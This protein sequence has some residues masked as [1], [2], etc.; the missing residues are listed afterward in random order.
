MLANAAKMR[1][2]L[3]TGGVLSSMFPARL[4]MGSSGVGRCCLEGASAWVSGWPARGRV[5]WRMGNVWT[6]VGE[7]VVVL[8]ITVVVEDMRF[9]DGGGWTAAGE[10]VGDSVRW[11]DGE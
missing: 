6:W 9:R 2:P 5:F 4:W 1:G 11:V 10:S 3:R 7:R 8:V